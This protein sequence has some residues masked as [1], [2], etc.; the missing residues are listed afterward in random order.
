LPLVYAGFDAN[1]TYRL[2]VTK[3]GG[4]SWSEL[5]SPPS[6]GQLGFNN[7]ITVGPYSL[8][9]GL[10]R[11]DR[12]LAFARRRKEGGVI[13]GYHVSPPVESNSW[14]VLG[15][16]LSDSNPFRKNL[17]LHGDLHAIDRRGS[18]GKASETTI[19]A[20]AQQVCVQSFTHGLQLSWDVFDGVPPVAVKAEIAYPDKHIEWSLSSSRAIRLFP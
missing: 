14:T 18:E 20:N 9:R 5:P 8:G 17:D 7:V 19:S 2:F 4:D 10:Y 1:G 13:N 6:D 15:C 12:V 3:D 11:P 16:C